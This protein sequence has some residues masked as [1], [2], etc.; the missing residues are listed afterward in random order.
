MSWFHNSLH[1]NER[2][3]QVMQ[4]ALQAWLDAHRDVDARNE[5][6]REQGLTRIASMEDLMG[7]NFRHCG[8]PNSNLAH[9]NGTA[10]DWAVAQGAEVVQHSVGP[11]LLFIAGAW[12]LWLVFLGWWRRGNIGARLLRLIIGL[13]RRRPNAEN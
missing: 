12:V 5:P 3:H 8:N 13:L 7:P 9:C 2:G 10:N 4:Y 11:L 6:R 1:P